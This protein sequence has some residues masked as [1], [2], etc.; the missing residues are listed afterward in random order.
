MTGLELSHDR[1]L[2]VACIITDGQL[3]KVDE[4]VS[5][6]VRTEKKVLNEMGDW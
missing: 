1:L 6:V 3:V 5:Y 4:G 2:E